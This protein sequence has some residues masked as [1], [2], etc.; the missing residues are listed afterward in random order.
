M[1]ERIKQIAAEGG[2]RDK[3]VN[4]CRTMPITEVR[5]LLIELQDRFPKR[6]D[7]TWVTEI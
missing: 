3:L 1:D 2:E 7:T 6:A 4:I 5:K